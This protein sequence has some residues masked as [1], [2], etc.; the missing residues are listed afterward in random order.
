M[1]KSEQAVNT[2]KPGAP[3]L[4]L[5]IVLLLVLKV[6]GYLSIGWLVVFAPILIAPAILLG[7]IGIAAVLGVVGLIGWLIYLGIKAARK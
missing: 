4:I 3:W 2:I 6:T 7:L 1:S 5:A